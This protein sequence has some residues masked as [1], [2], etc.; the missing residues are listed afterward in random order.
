M[1]LGLPFRTAGLNPPPSPHPGLLREPLVERSPPYTPAGAASAPF[2]GQP[3]S[4]DQSSRGTQAQGPH[5]NLRQ[6]RELRPLRC[7]SLAQ[8]SFPRSPTSAHSKNSPPGT[9]STS[10]AD[11]TQGQVPLWTNSQSPVTILKSG[12]SHGSGGRGSRRSQ[13]TKGSLESLADS[14]AIFLVVQ[15]LKPLSLNLGRRQSPLS[16]EQLKMHGTC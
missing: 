13:R 1:L 5:P 14:V 10:H 3:A 11:F 7:S 16:L 15:R 12:S 8:S 9:S 4:N 2:P 6:F